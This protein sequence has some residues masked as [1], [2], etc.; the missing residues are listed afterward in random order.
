MAKGV[1]CN[2]YRSTIPASLAAMGI[3]GS[4]NGPTR[5]HDQVTLVGPEIPERDEVTA[6]APA[7]RLDRI[8]PN[9][10]ARVFARPDDEALNYQYGGNFIF[11]GYGYPFQYAIPVHDRREKRLY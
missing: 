9:G 1:R 10:A 3:T 8:D 5:D 2:V 7:F 4:T 6:D 11:G